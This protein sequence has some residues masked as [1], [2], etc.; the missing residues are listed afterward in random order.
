MTETTFAVLLMPFDSPQRVGSCGKLL[1]NLSAKII[2]PDSGRSLGP[3]Q[4][5]EMCFK[6]DLITKKYY[7]NEEATQNAFDEDG[8]LRTGDIGYYDDEHYFYV[9]DRLKELIKYKGFQVN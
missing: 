4:K 3:H 7:E 8:W 9:I 1:A 5:G 2:E 6:G